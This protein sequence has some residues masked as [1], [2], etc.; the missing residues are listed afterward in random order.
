MA[1]VNLRP[2][3]PKPKTLNLTFKVPS[4]VGLEILQRARWLAHLLLQFYKF[5]MLFDVITECAIFL[6]IS[7]K[8]NGPLLAFA[9]SIVNL[10]KVTHPQ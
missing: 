9:P 10:L 8:T 7:S 3:D 6:A 4:Y 1:M 2:K 5:F